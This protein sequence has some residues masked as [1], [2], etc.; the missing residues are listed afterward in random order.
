MSLI[1]LTHFFVS[2]IIF[3]KQIT[4][5]VIDLSAFWVQFNSLFSIIRR[6]QSTTNTSFKVN[7][8]TNKIPTL[9]RGPHKY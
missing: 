1:F 8:K 6:T 5:F 7:H 3:A 9:R 4:I 2:Y